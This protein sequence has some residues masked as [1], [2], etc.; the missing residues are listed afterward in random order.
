MTWSRN[1]ELSGTDVYNELG[2]MI[3]RT[4][5]IWQQGLMATLRTNGFY[6]IRLT[7]I[8]TYALAYGIQRQYL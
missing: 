2:L 6:V 7:R 5:R 1:M 4:L 3:G 8:T